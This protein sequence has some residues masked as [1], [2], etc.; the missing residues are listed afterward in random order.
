MQACLREDFC[1]LFDPG[2]VLCYDKVYLEVVF[3]RIS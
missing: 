2:A 3:Q 1:G